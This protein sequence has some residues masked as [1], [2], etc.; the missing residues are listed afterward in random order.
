MNEEQARQLRVRDR[1]VWISHNQNKHG[2]VCRVSE[3]AVTKTVYVKIKFE[4]LERHVVRLAHEM[5]DIEK[6]TV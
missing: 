1:V 6:E 3:A 5:G 2:V 4:N